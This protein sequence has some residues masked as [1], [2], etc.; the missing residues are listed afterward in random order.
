MP[1]QM[2]NQA[3]SALILIVFVSSLLGCLCFALLLRRRTNFTILLALTCVFETIGYA[4]RFSSVAGSW[5]AP[6]FVVVTILLTI[7]PSFVSMA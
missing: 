1:S 7:A 3:V 5:S 6:L 4:I 2:L